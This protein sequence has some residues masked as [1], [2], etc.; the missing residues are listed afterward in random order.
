MGPAPPPLSPAAALLGCA[1]A[2]LLWALLVGGVANR[3]PPAWLTGAG[4]K[5]GPAGESEGFYERRLA[6]RRWKRWLPDAGN[7]LPGGVAKASLARRDPAVLRRLLLETHRAELVHWLLW[8]LW[9][10][11]ALWL[12]PAGVLLNLLFACLLNLPCLAAQRYTRR[13][14]ERILATPR[15][16]DHR[17]RAALR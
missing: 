16:T 12:P 10:V 2:W 13:R 9:I 17:S 6:I 11:T 7:A 1:L 5:A 15:T 3:L 14:L 8:P 4:G